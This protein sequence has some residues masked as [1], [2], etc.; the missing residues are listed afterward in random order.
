MSSIDTLDRHQLLYYDDL[1][2]FFLCFFF[3][4]FASL[5]LLHPLLF[6][7]TRLVTYV[8]SREAF[9]IRKGGINSKRC[10]W[11]CYSFFCACMRLRV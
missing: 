4:L 5:P 7:V 3:S 8:L 11:F 1:L 6:T 9:Y 10:F 2:F